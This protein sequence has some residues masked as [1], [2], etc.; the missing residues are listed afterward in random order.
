MINP[1][2]YFYVRSNLNIPGSYPTG[3]P[4]PSN[5][6]AVITFQA[7][8]AGRGRAGS[9]HVGGLTS[10]VYL[11]DGTIDPDY[12]GALEDLGLALMK[13]IGGVAPNNY[14]VP[15]T[16]NGSKAPNWNGLVAFQ[17]QQEM[18]VMRRRTVGLGI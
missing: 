3:D 4:I 17:V 13:G 11:D 14:W 8:V 7:E 15:V 12:N 10:S 5:S 16:Y 1:V 9:T 6:S 18:R 2:R